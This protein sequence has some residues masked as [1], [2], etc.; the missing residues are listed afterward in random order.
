MNGLGQ[1]PF[2]PRALAWDWRLLLGQDGAEK[3]VYMDRTDPR[4][5]QLMLG[6]C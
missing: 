1:L 6:R 4:S 3:L 2:I 5:T